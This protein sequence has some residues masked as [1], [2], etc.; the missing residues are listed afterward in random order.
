MKLHQALFWLLI[1]FLPTQLGKHFWPNFAF[2]SGIRVDYLSPTLYLTDIL[3]IGILGLWG[4]GKMINDQWLMVNWL[5]RYWWV[6]A[7]FIYLLTNAL[8]AQNQGA[9]LYKFL[10]IIEFGLLGLYVAKNNFL[11]TNYQLPISLAVVYSSL[12]AIAQ[13]LKQSSLGGIF[14]WLGE[15][16]FSAGTPGIS[17]GEFSG[18]LFL[19]PYGTFSHPNSLAGFFLVSLILVL[20]YNI[21]HPTS[22]RVARWLAATLG[23][24]TIVLSFSRTVWLIGLMLAFFVIGCR[25]LRS[26]KY[27]LFF[28][29]LAIF[30]ASLFWLLPSLEGKSVQERTELTKTATLIIQSAPLTGVGLNNFIVQL[31]KFWQAKTI[32][33]LQPAHN[34]F[35]LIT[36]E[37]GLV[38]LVIFLWFLYLT[39]KK[40]LEIGNKQSLLLR[41]WK[42]VIPL[43]VILLTGVADHYWFTLQQNQLL[44]T[45]LLG[46]CWSEKL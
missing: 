34:I 39:F 36:A 40:L 25:L 26:K 8:F 42:L 22:N 23:T 10:K 13:F 27:G 46:I 38:G 2:V 33:F 12:I 4:W 6:L 18:K 35:L 3:I 1:F 28:I 5:K 43:L 37:T 30:G 21:Q 16:S 11:I 24:I 17:L 14:W 7:I 44:L 45:I 41:N 9:A 31:P 32:Y 20:G 15:R 29:S 19:R